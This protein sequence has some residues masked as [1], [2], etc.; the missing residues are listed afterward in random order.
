MLSAATNRR[1]QHARRQNVSHCSPQNVLILV[2]PRS[3]ILGGADALPEQPCPVLLLRA[4]DLVFRT[5]R[6]C[7]SC[8]DETPFGLRTVRND[9]SPG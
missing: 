9:L 5:F 4:N 7:S 3:A 6:R 8:A 2:Q 1:G